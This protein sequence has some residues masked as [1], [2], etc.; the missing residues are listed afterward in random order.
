[1]IKKIAQ[2]NKLLVVEAVVVVVAVSDE[3]VVVVVVEAAVLADPEAPQAAVVVRHFLQQ[4]FLEQD[5]LELF[6]HD[7]HFFDPPTFLVEMMTFDFF[8]PL[9]EPLL[10][11]KINYFINNLF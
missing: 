5:F 10:R 8:D 4:L 3:A 9:F 6:L 1:M 2:G 11:F 7:L